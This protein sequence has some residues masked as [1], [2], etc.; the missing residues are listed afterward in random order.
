MFHGMLILKLAGLYAPIL[1]A[2]LAMVRLSPLAWPLLGQ[3]GRL[4]MSGIAGCW[5]CLLEN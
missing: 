5:R 2:V 3:L 4:E 1:R